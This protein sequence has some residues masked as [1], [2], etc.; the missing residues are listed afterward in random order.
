MS[1]LITPLAREGD[2]T[3]DFVRISLKKEVCLG[4]GLTEHYHEECDR[5]AVS[6]VHSLGGLSRR[7]PGR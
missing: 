4:V 3:Y 2:L 7:A 6:A 5:G 1:P